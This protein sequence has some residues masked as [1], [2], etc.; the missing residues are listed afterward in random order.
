MKRL[1]TSGQGGHLAGVGGLADAVVESGDQEEHSS[2]MYSI[3]GNFSGGHV[4]PKKPGELANQLISQ[5][6]QRPKP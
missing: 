6:M 2:K 4:A 1:G 3:G 5:V